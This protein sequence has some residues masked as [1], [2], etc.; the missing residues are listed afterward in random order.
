MKF[1]CDSEEKLDDVVEEVL[2]RIKKDKHAIV[3]GLYGDL[4]SGKTTFTKHLAKKL[5]ITETVTSP[6][7]ILQKRFE[8]DFY[9]F[10]NLYHIDMYRF[11]D[12]NELKCLNWQETID[13]PENIVVVE[14]P[15]RVENMIPDHVL[16]LYFTTID[17]TTREVE[18][19]E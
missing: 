19:V 13:N 12:E 18:V 14:W 11:E 10:K 5:D 9:S 16:R 6:T 4:G 15:D 3:I 8:I 7:F 17:E 2:K 1:V